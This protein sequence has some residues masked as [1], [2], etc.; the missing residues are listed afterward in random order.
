VQYSPAA[1]GG[2]LRIGRGIQAEAVAVH[3]GEGGRWEATWAAECCVQEEVDAAHGAGR[4]LPI[5]ACAVLCVNGPFGTLVLYVY[6]VRR[7]PAGRHE[8]TTRIL[9]GK[10]NGSSIVFFSK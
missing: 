3:G 1:A 6:Y 4:G 9:E 10:R 2:G 5:Y 7:P 8:R